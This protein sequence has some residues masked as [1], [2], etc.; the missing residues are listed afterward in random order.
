MNQVLIHYFF[1]THSCSS[2]LLVHVAWQTFRK[3][4]AGQETRSPCGLGR[5]PA[6]STIELLWQIEQLFIPKSSYSLIMAPASNSNL[7][8]LHSHIRQ[9]FVLPAD[10]PLVQQNIIYK[11]LLQILTVTTS[12]SLF[13]LHMLCLCLNLWL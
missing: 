5:N 11:L 1:L 2:E 6:C 8:V 9:F 4:E 3:A 7:A 10:P 13:V 12:K